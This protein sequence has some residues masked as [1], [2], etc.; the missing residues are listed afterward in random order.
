[1]GF[2]L[3]GI[4]VSPWVKRTRVIMTEKQIPYEADPYFPM[5]DPT[6]EFLAIS[7]LRK[8]PVLQHDGVTIPDSLAICAYVEK[9]YPTP[10]FFPAEAAD[11]AQA[12]WICEYAAALFS[13]VEGPIFTQKV[14][15]PLVKQPVD[16]DALAAAFEKMPQYLVYLDSQL[17]NRTF[18]AGEQ[19]S[20]AD[21]T[22]AAIM[23]GLHHADSLPDSATYPHLVAFIER[24]HGRQVF[25]DLIA[26]DNAALGRGA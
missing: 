1:M 11:L 6:P 10:A 24:M 18:F 12:L 7:P 9:L 25:Q 4:S 22:V 16:E 19:I 20:I 23:V 17:A 14:L 5:G 21:V 26:E 3:T 8:V 2:K 13:N 15:R